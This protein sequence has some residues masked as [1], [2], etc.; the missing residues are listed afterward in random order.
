M[1]RRWQIHWHEG[2]FLQP[3]HLQTMQA[4]WHEQ[5]AAERTLNLPY[6]YGVIEAKLSLDA[7]ENLLVHFDRLRVIMPSGLEVLVPEN[8]DLPTLEI[9]GAFNASSAP[10]D[11]FL[12]VPRW[13]DSRANTL[14]PGRDFD[15]RVKRLYR[16]AEVDRPDENTGA[17]PQTVQVRKLNARLLLTGDDTTDLEV[18]PLARI[19]HSADEEASKPCLS[20]D[21]TPPC[22]VL[23]GAPVLRELTR[24]ISNQVEA[25]RRDLA[26]QIV[27]GGFDTDNLKGRQMEQLLRLRTLNRFAATLPSWLAV[28]TVSPFTIYLQLREL[29]AELAALQPDR[30]LFAVSS[31]NH[32]NPVGAFREL[33]ARILSLLRGKM[34]PI[35]KAD[36]K[37]EAGRLVAAF[38]PDH[39]SKPNEYYLGIKTKQDVL[40]LVKLVENGD[41]FKLMPRSLVDRVVYGVTLKHEEFP[42]AELPAQAGLHY[43]RL[44]RSKRPDTWKRIVE[45]KAAALRWPEM[46]RA[47]YVA[48]V[49]MTVPNLE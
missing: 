43:F 9:K 24:D 6:P 26:A 20:P 40:S 46:D 4:G 7:L 38:E 2:L 15:Q 35:L 19:L 5:V 39:F 34:P 48:A 12:G 42:P 31:Y 49:Y 11:V 29:L 1:A 36:F 21:F 23:N 44:E 47:D 25:A 10:F 32:D 17:N 28:P 22:L 45:E 16:V 3:Q 13:F 14:E 18:I 27:R 30:D 8:T 33:K 37:P 41:Q